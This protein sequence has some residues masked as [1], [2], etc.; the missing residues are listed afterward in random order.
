MINRSEI[1]R[2]RLTTSEG[3]I[4]AHFFLLQYTTKGDPVMHTDLETG[5]VTM[6]DTGAEA[7]EIVCYANQLPAEDG[8]WL[9]SL[10]SPKPISVALEMSDGTLV[11]LY[12]EFFLLSSRYDPGRVELCL[13]SQRAEE[14]AR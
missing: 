3:R 13:V 10:S 5:A 6:L 1:R 11:A 14:S 4:P 12:H 2:V 9:E 7:H 8:D